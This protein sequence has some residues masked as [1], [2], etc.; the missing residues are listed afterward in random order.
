MTCIGLDSCDTRL[1]LVIAPEEHEIMKLC[2]YV[3][4]DKQLVISNYRLN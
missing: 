1:T 4:S 3:I 2:N